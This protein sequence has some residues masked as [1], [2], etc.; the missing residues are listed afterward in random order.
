MLAWKGYL[1][2]AEP[3]YIILASL[4]HPDAHE[5]VRQLTLEVQKTRRSLGALLL[6]KEELVPYW[7]RMTER[8]RQILADPSLYTGIAAKK[9]RTIAERW[10]DRLCP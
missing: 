8:Q 3:L 7:E 2:L 4:G 6:E 1:V 9:A 5:Q 10:R